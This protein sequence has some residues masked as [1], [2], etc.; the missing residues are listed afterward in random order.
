MAPVCLAQR[1]RIWL[2]CVIGSVCSILGAI[3]AYLIGVLA[4]ETI[5]EYLVSL[6]GWD[7]GYAS[8]LETIERDGVMAVAAAGITPI[9][10]IPVAMIA[11]VGQ[12]SFLSFFLVVAGIRTLRFFMMGAVYWAFGAT[13]DTGV[14]K[15]GG[16]LTAI[17]IGSVVGSFFFL[18][19]LF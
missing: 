12:M 6:Y 1:Q 3:C 9:P 5:G 13:I 11:G 8:L 16:L 18:P 4:M 19:L 7:A 10:F 17:A 2:I 14:R 15:F